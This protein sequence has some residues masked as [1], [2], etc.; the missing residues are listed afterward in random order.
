MSSPIVNEQIKVLVED[1]QASGAM[2]V[3]LARPAAEGIYPGVIVAHELFGVTPE[4]RAITDQIAQLGY[5]AVAP[6]FYHRTAAAGIELSKDEA[7]R[8]AGFKLM[9]QLTRDQAVNDVRATM[10]YLSSRQDTTGRTAMVGFSLGG[11]IA[12]LAA[13]QLDLAATAVLYGG[14]IPTSDIPLSQPA[15][16]ITLTAGIAEHDGRLLFLVGDQDQLIG[17]D[18]RRELKDALTAAHVRHELIVYPDTPHAFFWEGTDT[19]RRA[20]RD[21]AWRRVQELLAGEPA[22]H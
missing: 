5:A 14:W 6:E 11:H 22:Q 3:Y 2:G 15:P 7:G 10:R 20:A 19:Y 18:Q 1:D 12:Y 17:A 8:A 4:I 13:T 16:T 9:G 21:D